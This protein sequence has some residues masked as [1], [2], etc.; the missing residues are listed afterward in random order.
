MSTALYQ[1]A[2]KDWARAACGR[3]RLDAADGEATLDNPLC[4]DR[5]SL[6]V[7]IEEGRIAALAHETRGCLLCEAAASLIGQRASGMN[8]ADAQSI[9]AIVNGMLT[10]SPPPTP[11][12]PELGIFLPAREVP[13]RHKCILL[14]FR[15]LL[16]ALATVPANPP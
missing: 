4:G 9:V 11:P 7:R 12:W 3:G 6:Q 10:D 5:V 16:A 15:A 13:S 8:P 1:Q 14:P 2:I